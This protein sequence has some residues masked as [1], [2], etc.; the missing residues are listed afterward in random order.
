[1]LFFLSHFSHFLN[2]CLLVF[3][4]ST[5]HPFLST[6]SLVSRKKF[7]AFCWFW[8]ISSFSIS[9]PSFLKWLYHL[10]FFRRSVVSR[11]AQCQ[12]TNQK[13]T[14]RR[15]SQH[16][17]PLQGELFIRGLFGGI[18][19]FLGGIWFYLRGYL[20]LSWGYLVL[21]WTYLVLSW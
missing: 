3:D 13:L 7:L 10:L 19:F 9:Q 20:V 18:W 4:I 17:D 11:R 5:V 14:V 21:S 8:A 12:T 1:M 16:S 2:G 15:G 6:S